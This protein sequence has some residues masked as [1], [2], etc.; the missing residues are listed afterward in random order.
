MSR[1]RRLAWFLGGIGLAYV[2]VPYGARTMLGWYVSPTQAV[3]IAIAVGSFL[4]FVDLTFR[5]ADEV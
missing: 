2:G 5:T 3:G 1:R 4:V